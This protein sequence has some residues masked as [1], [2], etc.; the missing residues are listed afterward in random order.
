[1]ITAI[2]TNYNKPPE[3]LKRCIDSVVAQRVKYIIIDDASDNTEHLKQ[4]ENVITLDKNVGFYSAFLV[5]L[6]QVST[7]YVLKVDADDYITGIP[8]IS[9]GY[10][11]YI[12]NID[13]KITLIP[14]KFIARPYAGLGGA[15][16]KSDVLL[17]VWGTDLKY[18]GDIV[19]FTRLISRYKCKLN[20]ECL[21]VY[22]KK[23]SL[24]TSMD[25]STRMEWITK[26]K[27]LAQNE[28]N[29]EF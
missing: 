8:D 27:K 23:Y 29:K 16:V 22:D 10:D 24:I 1:M 14:E 3:I 17:D 20:D 26:A 6:K 13:E 12:N 11:A 28:I 7:E 25:F 4:Y 19:N 21:Y 9:S 15:V 5:G 18:Y 2:I